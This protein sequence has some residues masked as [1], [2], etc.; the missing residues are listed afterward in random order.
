MVMLDAVVVFTMLGL[1]VYGTIRLLGG[2]QSS[3]RPASAPGQWRTGHYERDG[4]TRIVLQKV[5]RDGLQVLDE[6]VVTS[7]RVDD[8]LYEERFLAGMATA[9]QR[10]ALFEAEDD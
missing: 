7:V 2:L 5:S 9:R 3:S 10:Q 4:E 1:V 8:P 6:H